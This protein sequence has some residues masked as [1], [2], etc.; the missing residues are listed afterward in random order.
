MQSLILDLQQQWMKIKPS[1]AVY[2]CLVSIRVL[3]LRHHHRNLCH[4]S[5]LCAITRSVSCQ[6][7]VAEIAIDCLVA[8]V[9]LRSTFHRGVPSRRETFPL[10][11][12]APCHSSILYRFESG[13]MQTL[14][15]QHCFTCYSPLVASS[16]FP[17]ADSKARVTAVSPRTFVATPITEFV[18]TRPFA[19]PIS[20]FTDGTNDQRS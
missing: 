3:W 5:P 14:T 20:E 12:H 6:R 18:D 15:Q 19:L 1:T 11:F 10:L 13:E 8:A 4:S 9:R 16:I 17:R 7:S 2:T